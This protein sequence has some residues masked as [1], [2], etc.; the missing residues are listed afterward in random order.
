MARLAEQAERWEEMVEYMKRVSCMGL[1]LT[2]EERNL[3]SVAFKNCVG[4]RRAAWRSTNNLEIREGWRGAEVVSLMKGYRMRIEEELLA[5]CSEVLEILN[6]ELIPNASTP[7]PKVFYLKM[8]GDYHRYLAEFT[9]GEQHTSNAQD[10]YLEATQIATEVLPSTHPIRLGLALNFSVFYYEVCGAPE[11]ACNLA[12]EA[13]EEVMKN[14][15]D[16]IMKESQPIVA[17][18]TDNLA[19]WTMPTGEKEDGKAPEQDGTAVEEL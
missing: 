12:R 18:L 6:K 16:E 17:L 2:T 11:K 4:S 9:Q 19:L 13:I 15:S 14:P 10:A 8:K 3:L 5:K 1:E 7:E